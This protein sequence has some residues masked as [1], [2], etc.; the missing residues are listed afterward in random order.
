MIGITC[1]DA[2][3]LFGTLKTYQNH[4]DEIALG[5][6]LIAEEGTKAIYFIY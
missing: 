2:K 5:S 1:A 3:L 4:I 6:N